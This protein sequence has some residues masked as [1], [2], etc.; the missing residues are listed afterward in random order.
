MGGV[1]TRGCGVYF[2]LAFAGQVGYVTSTGMAQLQIIT[3]GFDDRLVDLRLGVNRLGRSPDADFSITHATVSALHCELILRDIGVTVHDLDSTNG[4]F[5]NDEPVHEADLAAGQILRL[6]DVEL[7]V[8]NVDVTVAIP[9]FHRTELP[10]PPVVVEDGKLVCPRHR[11]AHVSHQ[12]T[13]CKEVMCEACVHRLRRK[14]GKKVLL[15]CPLCSGTVELFGTRAPVKKSLFGR[16][17][18]TIKLKFKHTA[19]LDRPGE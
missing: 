1:G 2:I 15:L 9:K 16:V 12:C 6:G 7:R 14:G 18:E 3:A 13:V 17:A 4:T 19:N 8:E 11:L 5:V 10:A